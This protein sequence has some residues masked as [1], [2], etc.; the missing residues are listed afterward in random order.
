MERKS[1]AT[2]KSGD[3]RHLHAS[4]KRKEKSFQKVSIRTLKQ[5]KKENGMVTRTSSQQRIVRIHPQ[6]PIPVSLS[7]AAFFCWKQKKKEKENDQNKPIRRCK[8]VT[9]P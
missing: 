5:M 1:R 7:S 2:I 6:I 4:E 8:H 3:C 9:P